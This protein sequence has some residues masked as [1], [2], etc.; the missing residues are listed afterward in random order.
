MKPFG[1]AL[2]LLVTGIVCRGADS[3]SSPPRMPPH[4]VPVPEEIR[5]ELESR[6]VA[7]GRNIGAL[8]NALAAKPA[9][10]EFL[11]DVQIYYNA[12]RYA[13]ADDIFY[14]TNDFAL[15]KQ[16]LNKGK[17]RAWQLREGKA[18]WNTAAGLVVRGYVSR[19]DG[20]VIPYGLV[21][22]ETFPTDTKTPRRLDLWFHGR[23]EQLSEMSFIADREKNFGEF[24]P[25]NTIVLHPYGRYCNGFKFAGEVDV[26]EAIADVERHY[27]VDTNRICD[28][29]FSMGGAAAWH[30]G[31]HYAGQWAAVAPG[32]GFVET[33]IFTK[34]FEKNPPPTWYE[35]KLWHYYDATDY[36]ANL[37]N[38]HVVAYSGE[39][40]G[41]RAAA[42]LMTKAMADEGMTLTHIIGPNT[43]HKYEPEAKKKVA[44]LVDGFAN[45]GRNPMPKQVKF[46][47]W[48]LRFNNMDWVTVD[49]MEQEWERA[50]V[51]A[52]LVGDS[53]I[54]VS[55]T[56][57]SSLTLAMPAGLCPLAKAQKPV[58]VLDDQ[59]VTGPA[60]SGDNSWTAHFSK[61]GSKWKLVKNAEG[62][63]L[64]KRHGLQ[65][66]I[67]D[68]FMDSFIMVRPT[69]EPLNAKLGAWA[70]E[71]LQH[72]VEEWHLQFRGEARVKDDSAIT[73]EDMASNNLILWGDPRSN[74][75]LAKLAGKLP[76]RWDAAGVRVGAST[77]SAE[78]HAPV[79][80]YPNPL[81]PK[82]YVVLNTGFTFC[83]VGR[84]SNA[85]QIPKLPDYAVVDIN[86][87][88]AKR[89]PEGVAMAGFFDEQWQL[90]VFD[91]E[92][93]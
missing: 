2:L 70:A 5:A 56:N 54:A 50:R 32:A 7:L 90:P 80:I 65:G 82:H 11:P 72:A 20:S 17:E 88:L 49:G 42:E 45:E 24:T 37:F 36:A 76:I 4:G 9:L 75:L 64:Q 3:P 39:I 51:N 69:G 66:P 68:A 55:T 26:F 14:K 48:N 18:P 53:K 40:D 79:L 10:L 1:I 84:P 29:G 67:D 83:E 71:G 52:E 19:I 46:T 77:Y 73:A 8:K 12:V 6:T 13:L 92:K 87:P 15:A 23:G 27:P 34:A 61:S 78:D 91:A 85:L 89:I 28:R 21:V 30:F 38:T 60:V 47:T 62:K 25:T 81:N 58:V 93:R 41:Q 22:P 16:F 44:A 86:V 33:A 57:V 35:Q 74:K 31:V 63:G 43:A 59:E